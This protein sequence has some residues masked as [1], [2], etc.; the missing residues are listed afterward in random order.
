LTRYCNIK[1]TR[2][3]RQLPFKREKNVTVADKP[4]AKAKLMDIKS[5]LEQIINDCRAGNVQG[6][7]DV[8]SAALRQ[9]EADERAAA[10]QPPSPQPPRSPELVLNSILNWISAAMG[11]PDQ[12]DALIAEM[13]ASKTPELH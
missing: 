8:A 2:K 11:H 7:D 13:S 3:T 5:T 4:G 9:A 12:L 10:G 6:A 1:R